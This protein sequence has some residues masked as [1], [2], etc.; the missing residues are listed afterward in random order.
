M[1]SIQVYLS[2]V[3]AFLGFSISTLAQV[4]TTDPVY[5][6]DNQVITIYFDATKGNQG[7][8]GYTGNVYA[9]TGVITNLSTSGSD[10][11]YVKTNWGVNTPETKLERLST[12]H[13]KLVITPSARSYYNVPTAETI[14]KM[15]FV[16]RS[17]AAVGGSFLEGKDEGNSDIFVDIYEAGLSINVSSPTGSNLMYPENAAIQVTAV[18]PQADSM[19]VYQGGVLKH[20]TAGINLDYTLTALN[21]LGYWIADTIKIKAWNTTETT[22]ESIAYKV[23]PAPTVAELPSGVIDG[24]NY[25]DNNT[26]VLSLYA[27]N[28]NYV[29]VIGDFNNWEINQSYYMNLT[30][31]G[32]RFWLQLNNLNVG[33]EYIFQYLVN[34]SLRIA[35]P[36]ADKISDPWNDKYISSTTYPGLKPYPSAKTSEPASYLQTGQTPY[37][38]EVTNFVPP[39]KD[40]LVIYEMLIRDFTSAHSYNSLIDT[41]GYL[42]TLG[43]NAIELMPVSEFEGNE[44]WGYNPSF[45]FAPDK[46]YGPKDTFKK[47]VDECHKRGIAVIM[48]VV[49][50][51]SYG[52]SPLVRLYW[53]S[54]LQR[55]SAE[56]PWYNEVAP[57]TA[58]SWGSDFDH[59]S[60][61][62]K[63]FVDRMNR[64]WVSEYKIDGYR[65]DFTKGFTNKPGD[66]WA[67]DAS[68]IAIIKRMA[69]SLWAFNPNT[70][71]ILEH[72]TDNAE[73]K[74]LS[75]YGLMIW[76]NMNNSYCE[77]AMGYINSNSDFSWVDYKKRGW[78]NP[79]VVGYM[80]SHDEERMMFK[81]NT[82]GNST[83]P[84]YKIKDPTIGMERA[85]LA[86]AFFITMPGPKMIWQFGEL[87]Y[88]FS[89]E[90][91]GRVG[92]KPIRWDYYTDWRRQYLYR[93][94]AALAHL[95]T[96]YPVFSTTDYSYT[97]T[98]NARKIV[99]KHT[100][101]DVVVSG[102]F[103]VTETSATIGFT[104]TGKW[105]DFLT[106][107]SLTVS[108]VAAQ[109][110]LQPGEFHV[111]T[112]KYI[113]KPAHLNTG[114]TN[115]ELEFSSFEVYPNPIDQHMN[116]QLEIE[117]PT[118]LNVTVL[119]LSGQKV[120]EVFN[121]MVSKGQ[122]IFTLAKTQLPGAGMYLL[123][124]QT[125]TGRKVS[126]VVV[127]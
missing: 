66:G 68:R 97:L 107:D 5:P 16:F 9:H 94:Y 84:L 34:G 112:T 110:T 40:K 53:N 61:Q 35:D 8:K 49:L 29:F 14:Q 103:G 93:L 56:N 100:E 45:Y 27:P 11:K 20:K 75:N 80:E 125:N 113:P 46:Y 99:L 39:A 95:K 98:G 32:K 37:N 90:Y 54:D 65:Y 74:I 78:T 63:A 44:S 104:K 6:T 77:A 67:Y 51:H 101:M 70:Y 22:I 4:V 7:L 57:N 127:K 120:L 85:G 115:E 105:Y 26:V 73:E 13:Y 47:F 58:Y 43:V 121:G 15:A 91:N 81:N 48:D 96:T 23:I 1:R 12:D 106:G 86:A 30:P 83:N 36:Y 64:Y 17:E 38:W 69:D 114:I 111:Y 109:V 124:V 18:S 72:F 126:K 55:P 59:E 88:D 116:I 122:E 31:D 28:K 119:N 33:Q 117:K 79:H 71:M 10:W 41:L 19:A 102:N 92:N 50:N 62:T 2:I 52:Q 76:G 24:I 3:L 60:D 123:V 89:I 25:I 42:Q 87:A 118:N 108:D 82:Y 21:T